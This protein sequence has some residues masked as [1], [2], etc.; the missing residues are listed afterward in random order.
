M[1]GGNCPEWELSGMG[2][3][4]LV[5]NVRDGNCP[6][7]I[8]PGIDIYPLLVIKLF[9]KILDSSTAIPDWSIE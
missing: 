2:I 5:G 8:C 9:N 3:F 6:D 1:S 7:G 4:R